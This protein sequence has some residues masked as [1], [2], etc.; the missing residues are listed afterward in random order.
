MG[1]VEIET[2]R[3]RLRPVA[4]GDDAALHEL[5][6]QPD[7]RRYLFDGETISRADAAEV[8]AKSLALFEEHGCGLWALE[9]REAGALE[10]VAG[11]WSLHDQLELLYAL[12]PGAWGRGLAAEAARA[13]VRFGFEEL[14]F[15]RVVASTDPPN[16]ASL[17]VMRRAGLAFDRR[18]VVD[19]LDTIF[20]EVA[21]PAFR[22]D[23]SHYRVRRAGE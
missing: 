13:L 18:E 10:G 2:V 19:G 1:H 14:G 16:A 6:T 5:F 4:E 23:G 8:V 17:G 11:Y 7:V 9:S 21:R 22:D 15:D 12:A 3:L 20:Y